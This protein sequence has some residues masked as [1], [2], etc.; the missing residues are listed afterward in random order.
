MIDWVDQAAKAW[1]EARRRL[2]L[3]W[4]RYPPSVAGRIQDGMPVYPEQRFPEVFTGSV[5]KFNLAVR[6]LPNLSRVVIYGHYV[7]KMPA[8]KKADLLHISHTTYYHLLDNAHRRVA[9]HLDYA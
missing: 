8:R 9:N 5:L 3:K 2:D 1:G 4:E 7:V 6:A